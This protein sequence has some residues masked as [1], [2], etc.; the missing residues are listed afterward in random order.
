MKNTYK[1]LIIPLFLFMLLF[2]TSKMTAHAEETDNV[3][4]YTYGRVD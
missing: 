2:G 4:A 1:I 3:Y